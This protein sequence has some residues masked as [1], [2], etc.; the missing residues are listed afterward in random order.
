MLTQK[1]VVSHVSVIWNFSPSMVL[2]WPLKTV[3][4][5]LINSSDIVGVR[6]IVVMALT[7]AKLLGCG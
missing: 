5:S 1:G 4:N 7:S 2:I 3:G 6:F